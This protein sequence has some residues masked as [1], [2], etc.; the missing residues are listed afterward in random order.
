[1][2]RQ[3]IHLKITCDNDA[4]MNRLEKMSLRATNFKP[5]LWYAE[6]QLK[7][8]NAENFSTG[9]LPS[10][11]WKPRKRQEPWPL[12][13]RT[14]KL[15]NSLSVLFTDRYVGTH[16]AEFG[17]K[18]EYAKYHQYGTRFMPKRKIAFEPRGFASDLAIKAANYV[19]N[20]RVP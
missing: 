9:G 4:A 6:E 11:G 8:A 16:N 1:M 7:K 12:M 14:G 5:I 3:H 15:M 2:T 17:T 20:A 10:G 18:V 19:A 13:I